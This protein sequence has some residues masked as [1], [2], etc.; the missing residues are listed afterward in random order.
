MVTG[1]EEE[2]IMRTLVFLVLVEV[3][4]CAIKTRCFPINALFGSIRAVPWSVE[5]DSD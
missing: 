2:L 5:V 4:E 3:K 1:A